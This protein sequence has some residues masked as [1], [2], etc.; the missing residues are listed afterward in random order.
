MTDI[1]RAPVT[2][3]DRAS[4]D[5]VSSA[6][7]FANELSRD[8][9][10]VDIEGM[11]FSNYEKNPVVLY[12]HDFSGRTE[13]GGLPI[14][15]TLRL[16]RTADGRVRA[17]F[18]FL[19]GDAFAERVRNAW[20][21]GFLRGASI[22]WRPIETRPG[23]GGP[24]GKG[25]RVVRSELIEWSI[26]AVPADPDALR[27]AHSLV[28]RQLVSAGSDD[29][30]AGWTGIIGESDSRERDTHTNTNREAAMPDTEI[31]DINRTINQVRDF[32]RERVDALSGDVGL[33]REENERLRAEVA[34][35]QE[36]RR[37]TRR[38]EIARADDGERGIRIASGRFAGYSPLDVGIMRSVAHSH[39]KDP[40]APHARAWSLQLGEATRAL[41][42]DITPEAVDRHFQSIERRLRAAY[43]PQTANGNWGARPRDPEMQYREVI[44]PTLEAMREVAM[45]A[46]TR[47][48]T[49]STT[50]GAGDEL[51]PTLERAELWMDVNLQTLV[52]GIIPTFP[53]PSQPFDIP[54]QLGDVNFYPGVENA[55]ATATALSTAKA[56]LTAREL[57]AQAPFS[58]S[59]DED[60][61]LPSLVAEIRAS[62]VRN[63]AET[64]DDIILNA[65]TTATNGI[66][67]D[68]ATLSASSAGKAHLLLGYDGLLH[69]PLVDNTAMSNDHGAAVSDDM[70]NEIRAKLG[71]YG[72]R[73]SELA[74]IM[75]VNTFIRAQSV[76]AFRT[77]DKLGP[78][79]TV[80]TGMLGAV[81]GIPVIVSEQMRLA[82]VDGKVTD[83]G[84]TSDTGR[85][86]LVN[87]NQWAQGYRRQP[88][89]DVTRDPSRR[90][91][92]VTVSF[93]HA[94]TERTGKRSS[95]THTALQY[96]ITGVAG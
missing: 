80:L 70:F 28:M 45:Q 3:G 29:D 8:G 41:V 90:Q 16:T 71:R 10:S 88:T 21:R 38:A 89:V 5:G 47:A 23:Q 93:R 20:N 69:L 46:V 31:Q 74:W 65:D 81:E 49:D 87:R 24:N 9:V 96:N 78:N 58:F 76:D 55:A 77:M 22:G 19:E 30:A 35:I 94:L 34:A 13:S 48:A 36:Q 43:V 61:A 37:A 95:A 83:G 82:D 42:A 59:L 26:V 73:P 53:M 7:I 27:G 64:L 63:S 51:V 62:L 52:G 1:I 57:V 79:A 68:E 75:D 14:A 25:V 32:A 18:E 44:R 72:V 17:E 6:T 91:T 4:E 2:L 39:R 56:T 66:N 84:N 86:L 67:A 50:A 85:L 60:N 12:A 15:R 40:D 54:T 11:D 92:V 33:L